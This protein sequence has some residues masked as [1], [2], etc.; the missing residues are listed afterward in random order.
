MES[1]LA[2]ILVIGALGLVIRFMLRGALKPRGRRGDPVNSV[3]MPNGNWLVF[4]LAALAIGQLLSY[5]QAKTLNAAVGSIIGILLALFID[6]RMAKT[7]LS[8]IGIIAAGISLFEYIGSGVSVHGAEG[9]T[10]RIALMGLV[11][12]CYIAGMLVAVLF[13]GRAKNAFD[14][15]RGRG[16]AFFGL[17]E[18]VQFFASPLGIDVLSLD[19][20]SAYTHVGIASGGAFVLGVLAGPFTLFLTSLGV[21][22]I[23]VVL[24][25]AGAGSAAAGSP[26]AVTMSTYFISACATFFLVR[27]FAGRF[28]GARAT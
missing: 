17:I 21:T 11:T 10:F 18:M 15:G 24:P 4:L 16:L 3:S 14:F 5:G 23:S 9:A 13:G 7:A 28:L 27:V 20:M 2:G 22:I 8:V 26:A 12:A 25:L 19:S 1:L 6:W